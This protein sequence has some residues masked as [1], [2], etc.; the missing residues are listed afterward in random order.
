[1]IALLNASIT[2]IVPQAALARPGGVNYI[3]FSVW[4]P[5]SADS[6]MKTG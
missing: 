3:A 2:K 4:Y 1:M 6:Q 5:E